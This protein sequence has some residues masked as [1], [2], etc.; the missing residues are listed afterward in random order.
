MEPL[1]DAEGDGS[2]DEL[3]NAP[4]KRVQHQLDVPVLVRRKCT[5]QL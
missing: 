5:H 3:T 1:L 2:G 4:C